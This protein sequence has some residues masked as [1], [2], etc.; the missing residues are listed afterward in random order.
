MIS[1]N[2]CGGGFSDLFGLS[3]TGLLLFS[4]PIQ[5]ST[6][7]HR[8]GTAKHAV[9]AASSQDVKP[10]IP[11]HLFMPPNPTPPGQPKAQSLG[12]PYV[13]AQRTTNYY[14]AS[15]S[16]GKNIE[17]VARRLNGVVVQPGETF[18]YY[19]H[20][21]PYT[22]QNGFGWGRAFDGDRIVPSMGGGVCQGASTLYSALLR[23]GLPIVERHNHGLTVPYLPAGEDATVAA[24]AHLDFRFKNNQSTP[25]LITSKAYPEKRFLTV[26]I[27]GKKPAPGIEV[28]HRVLAEYPYK[29]K[30]KVVPN[31]KEQKELF[32]GQAGGTVETWLNIHSK[33]G[34]IRKEI[35]VD[36]YQSSA[37]VIEVPAK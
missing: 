11:A 17:L 19:Q 3:M 30:R 4:M 37:H 35:G 12:L 5:I 33:M 2:E 26:A 8:V 24:S 21:G 14:H 22:S 1:G 16:Q 29:T 23:T 7:H 9:V 13:L 10:A 36:R 32:P 27:W 25:I 34:I 6:L 31:I 20:V 28:K 18:S 15:A